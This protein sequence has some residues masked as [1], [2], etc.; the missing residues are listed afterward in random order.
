M[1]GRQLA[2]AT[3]DVIFTDIR[4]GHGVHGFAATDSERIS[5]IRRS[6]E[7][8][9]G[10]SGRRTGRSASGTRSSSGAARGISGSRTAFSGR[11][12]TP[13]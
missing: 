4:S 10:A 7:G 9:G 2:H 6:F 1:G 5:L 8:I 13:A 12:T 3:H 11:Y